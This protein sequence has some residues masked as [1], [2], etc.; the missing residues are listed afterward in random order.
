MH[1]CA[2]ACICVLCQEWEDTI[3][4]MWKNARKEGRQRL[5]EEEIPHS[6]NWKQYAKQ[7]Y[8]MKSVKSST[9]ESN[10]KSNSK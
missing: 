3:N 6:H 2:R 8:D 9:I 1:V 10:H 4:E 5:K 7:C